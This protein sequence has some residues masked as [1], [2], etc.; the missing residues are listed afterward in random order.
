[1]AFL[2]RKYRT[3]VIPHFPVFE[4]D[5]TRAFLKGIPTAQMIE[6]I[7]SILSADFAVLAEEI[8]KIEQADCERLH[9]DV[10]DGRFVPN[11]TFGPVI[12]EAIR[13]RT[14]LVL[15]VHLMMEDKILEVKHLLE[16][17]RM[18]LPIEV[19]GGINTETLPRGIKAG[20]TR[21]VAGHAVFGGDIIRNVR[22]L[23]E[24]AEFSLVKAIEGEAGS[25]QKR[26]PEHEK[27]GTFD[28]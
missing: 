3:S 8:R 19:D 18:A 12:I 22:R 9:L 16:E 28:E 1:M 2:L 15:E 13:R 10:M 25:P 4:Y 11:I 14:A 26:A 17:K 23:R 7:P 6:I 21:L 20:A 5:D 24:V 27:A